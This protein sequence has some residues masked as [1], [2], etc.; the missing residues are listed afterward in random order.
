MEVRGSDNTN[1][2]ADEKTGV[3]SPID[4]LLIYNLARAYRQMSQQFHNSV[5]D[6]GLGLP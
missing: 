6:S 3:K 2:T 1:E 5:R 4:D